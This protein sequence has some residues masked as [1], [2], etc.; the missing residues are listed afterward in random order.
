MPNPLLTR[1]T[2]VLGKIEPTYNTDASPT[3]AADAIL[4]S[5]P[6]FAVD[7]NVLER[8]FTRNDLSP[9]G[10]RVG[11]KL[12]SMSFSVE[13]RSNGATNGG[14]LSNECKLGRLL[15]AC[16]Y[17]VTAI[18]GAGTVGTIDAASGNSG[19]AVTWTPGGAS[20]FKQR[21][22]YTI[23]VTTP[24]VS[25]TAEVSITP[26]ADAV[27]DGVDTAQTGV[28]LTSGT[29]ID[30]DNGGGGAT[31]TPS[32]SGSLDSGDTWTVEVSPVGLQYLPVS[33]S[34]ESMTL[35]MYKDGILHKMTGAIGTFS[36]NAEAGGYGTCE[37]EFTGQYVTPIDATL[38]SS[39]VFETT[40][41]PVF[42]LAKMRLDN[43]A[44][45][46]NTLSFEQ[47]NEIVPRPDANGS[48]GYNGVRLTGR[49][50]QGG[51]D[52]EATLVADH[53]FWDDFEASRRVPF[54]CRFGQTDGNVVWMFAP[55][56]QYSG[57]TY[58]DRDGMRVYDAGI[59]FT[60]V[61]G[62]DEVEFFFT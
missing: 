16:G 27:A 30:L 62:N 14:Q 54:K 11:R 23:E 38:P 17:S 49:N 24:G 2:V 32:W 15:R 57:L 6:M 29:A 60:R 45:V 53:S 7:P 47:Q 18:T 12:A 51:L 50:P 44:A 55:A 39:P 37:F 36:I 8:D 34:F 56:L 22:K 41:P 21:V 5:E 52:P 25:G 58:Q 13:L 4:V 35:Y 19:P 3:E 61:D 43:F 20:V 28:T 46:V 1:K 9:L 10:M 33:D 40:E 26:D 48:D 31:I 59:R 42:E